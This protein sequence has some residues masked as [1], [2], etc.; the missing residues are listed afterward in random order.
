M[1]KLPNPPLDCISRVRFAPAE[2]RFQSCAGLRVILMA[3]NESRRLGLGFGLLC[4]LGDSVLFD[5][6]QATLADPCCRT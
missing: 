5:A 6:E 4:G 1:T 3:N 2:G